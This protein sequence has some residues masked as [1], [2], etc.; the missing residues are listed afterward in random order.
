MENQ[1]L[2]LMLGM[3]AFVIAIAVFLR[4][5]SKRE[6]E[7]LAERMASQ[8][9]FL[10]REQEKM[11]QQ[12]LQAAQQLERTELQQKVFAQQQLQI[13]EQ[14][15]KFA[16]NQ[17]LLNQ[18]LK[19]LERSLIDTLQ[20]IRGEQNTLARA[21]RMEHQASSDRLS[22]QLDKRVERLA[23]LTDQ[24]LEFIRNTVD[25]RLNESLEQKF[26]QVSQRLAEV[27]NGL[28]QIQGLSG[29]VDDLKRILSNVKTRGIWGEMQLGNILKDMLPASRFIENVEVRP[30]SGLR[31]EYALILP[32]Q[33]EQQVLLPIDAKFPQEDYQRLQQAREQGNV[34]DAEVSLKQLERRLKSEAKDISDKYICPPYSTDFGIMYLPSEGLFAEAL[35]LAGLADELQRKYRVCLAG[36]TTLAALINSLQLGF[37]T[38]AV[39]QRTDEVWRLLAVV[40]QDLAGLAGA[41][42]KNA[43]KLEEA[44]N[45]LVHANKYVNKLS[46][47]LDAVESLESEK[48]SMN[49]AEE[50]ASSEKFS[51]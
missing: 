33:G 4:I 21:A 32:G 50:G 5:L 18:Q 24:K 46:R 1:M 47:R 29:G 37:R 28:G 15:N 51:Q 10:L 38:L 39:Q 22:E 6:Q 11:E 19:N 30:H 27:H 43:K 14:Q 34:Q 20:N 7:Q 49:F 31:V 8:Q 23:D 44:Q 45:S 35:N 2:S 40:K 41:L 36:P 13:A 9:E 17:A 42:E 25:E 3:G 26:A 16:E 48:E 12:R